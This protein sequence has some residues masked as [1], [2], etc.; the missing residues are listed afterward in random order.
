MKKPEEYIE[1]TKKYLQLFKERA[2]DQALYT[3]VY[4]QSYD[5][6]ISEDTKLLKT[7]KDLT[8]QLGLLCAGGIDTHGK[9]IFYCDSKSS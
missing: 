7:I 5:G 9:R 1:A 6:D 2:K 8:K 3:E 4:Y